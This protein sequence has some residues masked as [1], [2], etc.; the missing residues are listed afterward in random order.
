MTTRDEQE[1]N[2]AFCLYS[3]L[4]DVPSSNGTMSDIVDSKG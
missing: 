1:S 4:V 3:E 2:A